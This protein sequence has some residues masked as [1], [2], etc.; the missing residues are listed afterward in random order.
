M[1]PRSGAELRTAFLDNFAARGHARVPSAALV[2]ANDPTLLF[3]SAGMVQFKDLFT[4]KERRDYTRATSSQKCVRA[5]GKHNDL[6]NVGFT[7]RHHT[8]FEMLGNFSFGD[9]FKKDAI[10]WA[11]E[12]V[13]KTIGIPED[14]LAITIFAGEDKIPADSEAAELWLAQG[15]RKERVFRLGRA[16]NF[17]QAGDT[18]PCGPC[19]EIHIFRGDSKATSEFIDRHGAVF[20][21]ENAESRWD[22]TLGA[23]DG[24]SWMEIWN[25]VF[26]QFEM[27]AGGALTP[28][29]RPSIDTGMGLERLSAVVQ[30]VRS[31]YD[32]DL[33]TPIIRKAAEVTG[34][35]YGDNVQ[36]DVAM[37]VLAD[38]ARATTFLMA[39]GVWPSNEGRGYVLRRIMRRAI[40][41]GRLL[42]S[43]TPG[44]FHLCCSTVVDTMRAAYPELGNA[45]P[46]IS[47][48]VKNETESF[49]AVLDRGTALLNAEMEKTKSVVPGDVV[50]R[51]YDTFGFPLDL[52]ELM[53]RERGLT[54][55]EAAFNRLMDEQRA[56]G[57]FAGSGETGVADVYKSLHGKL[58]DTD[59]LGYET[60]VAHGKITALIRGGAAEDIARQ[61]DTVQIITDRTP[62][63]G[64]SGG[65][66][67]DTGVI[68][69]AKARAE[70][71]DCTR[72]FGQLFVH[73]A[74]VLEGELRVGDAIELAVDNE[75]R[76][77]IRRNHSATH[78]LHRVLK[79]LLG[80]H[81][82]QAGSVVHPDYLRFD[83]THMKSLSADELA[84]VEERVNAI[85]VDNHEAQTKVLPLEE[86]RKSGAAAL[87]G[88]KY[89][90]RVRVLTMGPSMELCGGTHVS[91]TG[92]IGYFK[93]VS[94]GAIASG[95]R[96]LVALTGSTAVRA[97]QS[98]EAELARAA[99]ALKASPKE[100]AAKAAAA[101]DR[102]RDLEKQLE[103]L[104]G[105]LA[106]GASRDLVSAARVVN[107]VKVLA[108]KSD[109]SDPKALRDLAD[110]LR[111]QLGSGIVVLGAEREG[112][113]L[114]LVAVTKDLLGR[115]KAGDIVKKLSEVLGGS[116]G[117][118]PDLAQAGGGDPAKLDQALARAYEIV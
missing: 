44:L 24:D 113:A 40:R 20:F 8:F 26:M 65:Q 57:S 4:G 21:R 109:A 16:D 115:F 75:R 9:Y 118:K 93:I 72:P 59:F 15:V 99:I 50:F 111:D 56:R 25:L 98:E 12:F 71:S 97:V 10:A 89:G 90:D 105:K 64:E 88:E 67:G 114:L 61:G 39:D 17:W 82:N 55:D 68:V 29:P 74:R 77:A 91:R 45:W 106:A 62:F 81:V 92:D 46:T 58:G 36:D 2:P 95:V 41:Y 66:V 94:E 53:A 38:H 80:A 76:R 48:F 117:G 107:G 116:G 85:V 22:K 28:L 23:Y 51:L 112:K 103:A 34:K 13:T 101:S 83:F 100:I 35:R 27:H 54:V 1:Q 43:N 3:T 5:G 84:A 11:W 69:S 73:H 47:D 33:F 32:T 37:R 63:Y 70:L 42:Q 30:G 19:S 6:E 96:R 78:L 110:K 7:A 31:N 86:A 79:D 102:I 104:Q 49:L 87:F 18:G 108:H 60:V 14:K 52:T